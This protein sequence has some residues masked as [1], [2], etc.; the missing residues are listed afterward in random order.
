MHVKD[1]TVGKIIMIYLMNRNYRVTG[2]FVS[3]RRYP[4]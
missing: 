1:L 3:S 2:L 4:D